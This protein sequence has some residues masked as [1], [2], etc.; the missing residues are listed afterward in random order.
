[1]AE[2][3]KV[4]NL[5][6]IIKQTDQQFLDPKGIMLKDILDASGASAQDLFDILNGDKSVEGSVS[7]AVSDAV[8]SIVDGAPGQLD[9]L[10][11]YLTHLQ[12]MKLV[13]QHFFKL[14]QI[15]QQHLTVDMIAM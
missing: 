3:N 14:L 13:Q 4:A 2:I 6:S 7:K 12:E 10:K 1:M 9:T 11:R 15:T 5:I 8:I